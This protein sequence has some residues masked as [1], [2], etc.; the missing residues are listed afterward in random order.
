MTPRVKIPDSQGFEIYVYFNDSEH[1]EPHC[2]VY[3]A[4]YSAT[5]ALGDG[6]SQPRILASNFKPKD[7]NKVLRLVQENRVALLKA[8]REAR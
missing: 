6:L 4:E 3:K 7:E 2:H 1:G 5:V 8:W